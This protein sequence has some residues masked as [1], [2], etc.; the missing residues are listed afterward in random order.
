MLAEA[1]LYEK[2]AAAPVRSG[3]AHCHDVAAFRILRR[4]EGWADAAR[5]S[6]RFEIERPADAFEKRGWMLDH[7]KQF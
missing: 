2:V 7:R 3:T 6:P 5:A 4:G 1:T